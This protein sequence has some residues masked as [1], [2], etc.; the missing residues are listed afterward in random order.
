MARE[1]KNLE[2]KQKKNSQIKE[3]IKATYKKRSLR[4]FLCSSAKQMKA[5]FQKN[6]KKN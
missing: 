3:T 2:D 1:Y 6:K 5:N 4:K